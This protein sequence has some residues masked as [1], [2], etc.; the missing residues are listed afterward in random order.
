MEAESERGSMNSQVVME[1]GG[2]KEKKDLTVV[3]FAELR[4]E[5]ALDVEEPF[6][7]MSST[8]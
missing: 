3:C 5:G 1:T 4:A 8:L 7:I 6:F 2:G